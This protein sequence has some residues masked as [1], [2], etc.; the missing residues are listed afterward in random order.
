M[1]AR[2]LAINAG[3]ALFAVLIL[4]GTSPRISWS[5]AAEMF[6]VSLVFANCI[7]FLISVV[8]PRLAPRVWPRFTFPFNW[9]VLILAMVA[10]A[11]SGSVAAIGLLVLVGYIP[12]AEFPAWFAGSL[13]ISLLATL[14]FGVG[15][16]IFDTLRARL[17]AT[18]LALRT[19]ERDEADARRLA[20]EARLSALEA[21]VQPHFLFNTLNSIAALI[22]DDPAGAERM[23]GR[24]AGLMRASLDSAGTPL[25]ALS[26]ELKAVRDYLEIERVRFGDRLRYELPADGAG[27]QARV[28]RL[29][30]Q[31]LVENSVKYAV[32][33]RPG[34]ARITV[35]VQRTAGGVRLSV[36]DDGPGFDASLIPDNHGLSLLRHRLAATFGTAATLRR[37]PPSGRLRRRPG[38]AGRGTHPMTGRLRAYVVDDE[39]LAVERVK[40]LL[41]ATGRVEIVGAASDPEVA[42]AYLSA[43]AVD[44]LFLDIQMPGLTGFDLLAALDRDIRVV[45]TT[46]Y[47]EYAVKAFSVN[48]IDYLLKPIE[49][50]RLDRA[51]DKLE[52]QTGQPGP[53]VRTLAREL[54]AQLQPSRR[55]ERVASRVGERTTLLDVSRVTH[56]CSRDKLTYAVVNGREHVVAET[57]GELEARL[58][59]RRFLRIHRATIV[60]TAFVHELDAWVDGGVLVRLKD[61]AKTELSVARDRVRELKTKLG[62]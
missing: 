17:E 20:A 42:L 5:A 37:G 24:L 25:V 41:E 61:D 36:E 1:L 30:L 11:V 45:F 4:G 46:A 33:P 57:L 10:L 3:A 43:Q 55:L 56:F 39:R 26:D 53:D 60:N 59:A 9:T 51:L 23:V 62:I 8:M 54:A 47:D 38:P 40:R 29:S 12:A 2:T 34:G 31:T 22:P 48:A 16:T 52:R 7:G 13:R 44:V 28:P 14:T 18:T 15:A 27:A 35:R 19:K 21:R 58:D 6:A 32:S 49:P 50:E